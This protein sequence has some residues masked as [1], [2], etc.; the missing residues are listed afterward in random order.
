M[1]ATLGNLVDSQTI[2]ETRDTK[3]TENTSKQTTLSLGLRQTLQFVLGIHFLLILG[4]L[5]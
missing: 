2:N 4:D 3:E 5:L 1:V